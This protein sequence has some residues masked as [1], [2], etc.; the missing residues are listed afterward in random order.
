MNQLLLSR[1]WFQIF[2]YVHPLFGEDEPNLTHIFQMGW[3]NHQPV[4]GWLRSTPRGS[5]DGLDRSIPPRPRRVHETLLDGRVSCQLSHEK[6]G[7]R[8]VV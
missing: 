2:L 4:I 5:Q 7:P 3:F 6:K 8:F 1:W